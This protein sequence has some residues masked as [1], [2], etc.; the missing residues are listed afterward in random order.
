M[1]VQNNQSKPSCDGLPGKELKQ[2]TTVLVVG[3]INS[4][5]V[6]R[7][8]IAFFSDKPVDTLD[9][10]VW[11][12]YCTRTVTRLMLNLLLYG[13]PMYHA[14]SL[15]WSPLSIVSKP[16]AWVCGLETRDTCKFV[17]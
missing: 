15:L 7:S 1:A 6:G 14:E 4:R 5:T 8:T 17:A 3:G 10:L 16:K 11:I 2:S 12:P 13:R 9:Y